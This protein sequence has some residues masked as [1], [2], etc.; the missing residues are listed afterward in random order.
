[1]GHS[2]GIREGPCARLLS[3]RRLFVQ[4]NPRRLATNECWLVHC[5]ASEASEARKPQIRG[6]RRYFGT[7]LARGLRCSRRM[8]KQQD[9]VRVLALEMDIH[10]H[11]HPEGRRQR[12]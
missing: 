4:Q 11:N 8:R 6:L 7:L 9:R 3:G 1:M 5:K 12:P 2:V 10:G